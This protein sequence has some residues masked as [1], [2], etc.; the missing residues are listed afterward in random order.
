M[1]ITLREIVAALLSFVLIITFCLILLYDVV[2]G[3]P[4]QIPDALLVIVSAVTGVYYGAT[5]RAG[6]A[7]SAANHITTALAA[8]NQKVDAELSKQANS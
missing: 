3:K 5:T 7:D 8:V 2:N 1:Q 4:V 6:G